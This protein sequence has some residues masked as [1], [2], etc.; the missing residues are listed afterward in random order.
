M[1]RLKCIIGAMLLTLSLSSCDLLNSFGG[2]GSKTEALS[3]VD[4]PTTT[5]TSLSPNSPS[6]TEDTN[7]Y[8]TSNIFSLHTT[9]QGYFMM[10]R[11]FILDENDNTKHIY[12]N[13]YLYSDDFFFMAKN[14]GTSSTNFDFIYNLKDENDKDYVKVEDEDGCLTIKDGK[15]GVYNLI[16]DTVNLNFD[17]EYV[18][19]IDTPKYDRINNC[20]IL[21]IGS[22]QVKMKENPDNPDE[23]YIDNYNVPINGSV[24]FIPLFY[25]RLK[26][27]L[28]S[29][30]SQNIARSFKPRD[31]IHFSTGGTYSIYLNR[32]TYT[33]RVVLQN[34]ETANYGCSYVYDTT[35]YNFQILEPTDKPY[36]FEAN[37][38][39]TYINNVFYPYIYICDTEKQTNGRSTLYKF[40]LES[41]NDNLTY[42]EQSQLYRFKEIGVYNIKIDL[43]NSTIEATLVQ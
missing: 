32:N 15:D 1:K 2:G 35:E 5:V 42:N 21:T 27:H 19:E 3:K 9:I 17:L 14:K 22:S 38:I 29:S 41:L 4:K 30:V 25:D 28:D 18:G 26:F 39:N 23:L 20:N 36:L 12:K 16:F 6:Q 24:V 33:V 10:D 43:L 13:M 40:K 34:K 11:P 37:N 31:L 8:Y 7:D